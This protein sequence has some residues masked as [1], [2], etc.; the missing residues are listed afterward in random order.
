[1]SHPDAVAIHVVYF[2]D[3]DD[4]LRVRHFIS[5]SNEDRSDVAGKYHEAVT[6]LARWYRTGQQ[7]QL[8]TALSIFLDHADK[9]YYPGLPTIKKLSMMHHL[10][11]VGKYLDAGGRG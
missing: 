1:M 3:N 9:G 11:L 2:S 7:R 4:T 8:T 10:E 5:D 6:K